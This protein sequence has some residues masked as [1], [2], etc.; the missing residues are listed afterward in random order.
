[1]KYPKFG[2]KTYL[3]MRMKRW[4][5]DAG[6]ESCVICHIWQTGITRSRRCR[7]CSRKLQN[8]RNAKKRAARDAERASRPAE[9]RVDDWVGKAGNEYF[10]KQVAAAADYYKNPA[11]LEHMSRLAGVRL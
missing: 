5:W 2:C 10:A 9:P 4:L 8:A 7:A 6:Y 1:M 3:E 11:I